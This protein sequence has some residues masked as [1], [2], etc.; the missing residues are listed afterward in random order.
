MWFLSNAVTLAGKIV[1]VQFIALPHFVAFAAINNEGKVKSGKAEAPFF[2]QDPS[3]GLCFCGT[4]FRRCTMDAL[5]KVDGGSPGNYQLRKWKWKES[6]GKELCL[7]RKKCKGSRVNEL[8]VRDCRRIC[9]EK[10]DILNV[11]AGSSKGY[12][13]TE[14]S[15][16][17]PSCVKRDGNGGKLV[18]CDDDYTLLMLHFVSKADMKM[19]MGPMA[20]L[21]T[22]TLAKDRK[23][24]E[25]LLKDGLD[26]N[27]RYWDQATPIIVAA[28]E[29]SIDMVTLLIKK[30]SKQEV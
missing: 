23:A 25:E 20:Q 21:I 26:V 1:L 14:H 5:W 13:L 15:F 28:A 2:L 11:N 7:D 16:D 27:S 24:I 8:Q 18:S 12:V 19:M 9:A 17:T 6:D 10:W 30:V 4:E 29:G 3:D 22:A